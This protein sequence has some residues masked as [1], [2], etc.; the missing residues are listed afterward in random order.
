M[1]EIPPSPADSAAS[2]VVSSGSGDGGTLPMVG[3]RGRGRGR[4]Q[5]FHDSEDLLADLDALSGG[6]GGSTSET[7]PPPASSGARPRGGLSKQTIR[8]MTELPRGVST[9]TPAAMSE[10]AREEARL[11]EEERR[12]KAAPRRVVRRRLG[13]SKKAADAPK[14]DLHIKILLLG[15]A[16]EECCNLLH[17]KL[18][19]SS[20]PSPPH[21]RDLVT[22]CRSILAWEKDHCVWGGGGGGVLRFVRLLQSRSLLLPPLI[23]RRWKNKSHAEVCRR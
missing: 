8:I 19:R 20:T 14:H 11:V 15:D 13:R 3:G 4:S 2:S 17:W 21:L 12:R 5:S 22:P 18:C 1:A 6:E 9:S 16:G 7:A 23:F 10:E